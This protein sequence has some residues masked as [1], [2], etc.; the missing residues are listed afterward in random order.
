ME[1]IHDTLDKTGF[2]V[3]QLGEMDELVDGINKLL[4]DD[5][6]QVQKGNS[7]S[8]LQGSINELL[9]GIDQIQES[10]NKPLQELSKL[11]SVAQLRRSIDERLEAGEKK[12]L[13]GIYKL[14]K[15]NKDAF[16][17]SNN[18]G[19][20][21]GL[22]EDNMNRRESM[23]MEQFQASSKEL[24]TRCCHLSVEVMTYGGGETKATV[25]NL[26]EVLSRAILL[27]IED[28]W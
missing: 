2:D 24:H 5:D 13:E 9:N 25:E 28:K 1:Y 6:D 4:N 26:K 10:V 15:D 17:E 19:G 21:D 20:I 8:P 12:L 16:Q 22:L 27:L 7:V 11:D 3:N 14:I 23:S 18:V